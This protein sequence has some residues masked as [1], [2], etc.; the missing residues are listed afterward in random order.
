MNSQE[1]RG[2]RE[3][4]DRSI[5]SGMSTRSSRSREIIDQVHST[6]G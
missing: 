2:A 4:S 6:K 5:G 1:V 3:L